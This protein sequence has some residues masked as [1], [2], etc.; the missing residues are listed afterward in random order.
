MFTAL[1][2]YI[3]IRR[4]RAKSSCDGCAE[5]HGEDVCSGYKYQ[6]TKLSAYEQEATVYVL[7]LNGIDADE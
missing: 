2:V 6:A 3:P 1:A 7:K 4:K 5:L